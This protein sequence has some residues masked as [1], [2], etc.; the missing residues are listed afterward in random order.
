MCAERILIT[1]L[2]NFLESKKL[3]AS[4]REREGVTCRLQVRVAGHCFTMADKTQALT[5]ANTS[6]K[7]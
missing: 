1:Q 5:N 6:P 7:K 2:H 3:L 4:N